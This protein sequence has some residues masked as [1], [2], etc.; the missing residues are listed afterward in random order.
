MR[1]QARILEHIADAASVRG[2]RLAAIA[3]LPGFA[4]ERDAAAGTALQA[5]KD[6][7]Q[8]ALAAAARPEQGGDAAKRHGFL[9]RQGE[10]AE[11]DAEVEGEFVPVS[12][13]DVQP[14]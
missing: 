12:R 5:G 1:E 4:P 11:R 9:D 13:H 3:L 7:Q 14:T 8:S 2:K 10:I 6:A